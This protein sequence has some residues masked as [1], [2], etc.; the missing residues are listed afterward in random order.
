MTTDVEYLPRG[1]LAYDGARL[2]LAVR[3]LGFAIRRAIRDLLLG[4]FA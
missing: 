1:S 2:A 4:A 3:L